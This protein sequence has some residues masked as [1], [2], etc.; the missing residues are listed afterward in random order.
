[1]TLHMKL[2]VPW[3]VE[4]T[5][6]SSWRSGS[7]DPHRVQHAMRTVG[8]VVAFDSDRLALTSELDPDDEA[9]AVTYIPTAAI[10]GEPRDLG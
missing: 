4:V 2:G 3:L 10:V 6:L 7:Y 1:M 5:W 9:G 8:Y